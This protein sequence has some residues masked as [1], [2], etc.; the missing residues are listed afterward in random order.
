MATGLGCVAYTDQ[1]VVYRPVPP[2]VI[3]VEPIYP[4]YYGGVF[5]YGPHYHHWRR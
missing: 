3:V 5:Y 4:N 1:P 2:P